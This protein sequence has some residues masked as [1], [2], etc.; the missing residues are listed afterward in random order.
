MT[1]LAIA[2]RP[3]YVEEFVIADGITRAGKFMLGNVLSAFERVEFLQQAYLLDTIPYL[4]ALGK[5]GTEAA[6]AILRTD[7]DFAV[8]NR[9]IGRNLNGR[10]HDL[11]CIE[12]APDVDRYRARAA[13]KDDTALTR[14]FFAEKRLPLFI[15]HDALCHA[16]FFFD[17]FPKV[18]MVVILRDPVALA[19]SWRK[20]GWGKRFGTDPKSMDHALQGPSGPIPWYA[21]GWD[22]D[23]HSLGEL[24]RIV[25]CLET[26]VELQKSQYAALPARLKSRVIFVSYEELCADPRP[27]V[28][29]LSAFLGAAP[30]PELEGVLSRERLPRRVEKG[31][32]AA[33]LRGLSR[34]M[35][36]ERAARLKALAEEYD[37][38][39]LPLAKSRKGTL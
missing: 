15:T 5:V 27:S 23:Y 24:D 26:I 19:E 20:R 14:S 29:R 28:K 2:P 18:K 10:P 17:V 33:P 3:R 21:A 8:Y 32:R 4:H 1:R 13:E 35:S 37:R 39:W 25:R 12:R 36:R 30:L 7:V 9:I 16:D 31:A 22:R 11:S 34:G 38:F 6:A